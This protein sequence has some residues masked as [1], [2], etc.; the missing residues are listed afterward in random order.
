MVSFVIGAMA[1]SSL[2]YAQG[3][4]VRPP[5]EPCDIFCHARLAQRAEAAG[6]YAEQERHVRA[7]AALAPNHPGVWYQVARALA[8]RG[9][10]DSAIAALMRLGAMGDTRDPHGDVVFIPLR[11]ARGYIA[12]RNR[13]LANQVPILDGALAFE[14]PDPDFLPEAL[15]YDSTRQRFLVGSLHRRVIAAVT[16]NGVA[17]PFIDRA[18]GMLRVVGIHIDAERGRLWFATWAPDSTRLS[19][20]SE[21]PSA[22]R[23]FLADLATGRIQRS[24]APDGGR[25]G[26]LLND[27]VVMRDGS[28]FITDTERGTIYRLRSPSDTLEV[29]ARPDPEK[30]SAANGITVAPDGGALYVAFIEGMARVD[31]ATRR[32][33]LMPA[34]DSVSTAAIDGLY[35]HRGSLVAVQGTPTMQRVVRYT[36]SDDGRRI[37]SAIVLE[38]GLTIVNQPTTGTIVGTQF[39]YIANSQYGRLDESGTL[40]PPTGG[41]T[42]TAIRVI[43]LRW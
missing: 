31:I 4:Q 3:P 14:L 2:L 27:F 19:D 40:Q 20:S 42:R 5:R 39:Y 8:R 16:P 38:R 17:T 12:A 15:A 41:P 9:R 18:P 10:A 34:P 32:V 29:F 36:L 23:L 13:L 26:H 24:W 21:A 28:L 1:A 37:E 6:N 7:I 43:D 33:A 22:T 25:P 35:W 11:A 30:F